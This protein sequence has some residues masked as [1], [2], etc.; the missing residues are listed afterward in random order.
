ME[1]KKC[2][3]CGATWINNQLY[4]ATNKPGS[5]L[6]LAGLVCNKL[7]RGRECL[8]PCLGLSGGDTWE[9]R[10]SFVKNISNEFNYE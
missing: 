9:N 1:I 10:Q 8:N 4:W 5:E 2:S 6:D 7:S 3:T